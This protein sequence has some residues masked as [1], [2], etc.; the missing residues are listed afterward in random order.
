MATIL[1]YPYTCYKQKSSD[2]KTRRAAL[3]GCG[4]NS[5]QY[6]FST[7]FLLLICTILLIDIFPKLCYYIITKGN[8]I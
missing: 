7:I 1:F 6:T 5:R 4:P 3:G 8:G 2:N